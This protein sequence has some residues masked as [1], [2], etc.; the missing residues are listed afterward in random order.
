MIGTAPA[1]TR[2]QVEHLLDL[3]MA[4]RDTGRAATR[5]LYSGQDTAAAYRADDAANEA[6]VGALYALTS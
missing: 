1:L 3:Y 4:T 6:M 5:A 2:E